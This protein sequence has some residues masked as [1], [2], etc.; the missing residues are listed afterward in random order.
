[1]RAPR[2]QSLRLAAEA[3][4][5]RLGLGAMLAARP[6]PA[7]LAALTPARPPRKI[8]PLDVVDAALGH[9]ERI[10]EALRFVPDTCLYRSLARYALLRRAGHPA[11]FVMGIEPPRGRAGDVE[12]H[13]WVELFGEPY[14]ETVDERLVVTYAYPPPC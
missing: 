5:L 8:T 2:L 14:G 13:A 1:M 12:G 4:A 3:V 7:L 10:A 6:L 9:A 11:R